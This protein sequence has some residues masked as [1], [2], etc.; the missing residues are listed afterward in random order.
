[1][2]LQSSSQ[3]HGRSRPT[4]DEPLSA[5]TWQLML[6]EV[7]ESRHCVMLLLLL[8]GLYSES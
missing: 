3:E 5:N 1:M 7:R 2:E 4:G 6:R 8:F